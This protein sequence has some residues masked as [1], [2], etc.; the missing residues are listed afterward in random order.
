MFGK[1]DFI[2]YGSTGVCEVMNIVTMKSP[3][4]L[5]KRE[6]YELHP[7]NQGG[8]KVFCP[9]GHPKTIMRKILNRQE[10]EE[11]I[12]QIP[13]IEE[14]WTDNDKMREGIYKEC[15]KSGECQEWVK[16]IKSLYVRK[17][18]R[19]SQGKKIPALEE[20]YLKMAE[21]TLYSELSIPLGIPKEEMEGY[22]TERLKVLGA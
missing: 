10:A 15:M 14:I 19:I 8:G 6:Y 2:I 7:L 21:D 17:M 4:S 13:A 11:L 12:D 22:I 16:V 3:G 18:D 5:E 9:T 1:G 20:K